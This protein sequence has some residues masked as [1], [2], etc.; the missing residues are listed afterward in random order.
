MS[1]DQDRITEVWVPDATGAGQVGSG[2]LLEDGLVLTAKHVLKDAQEGKCEVRLLGTEGWVPASEKWVGQSVDAALLE[3]GLQS[4]A[5]S[6]VLWG[7]IK[8]KELTACTAV[9]FPWAQ[10]RPDSV[11]DTEQLFGH[12]APVTAVK[13]G[14]YGVSV[15]TSP[16]APRPDDGSPWSGMSGA[17]LFSGPYLVGV[18]VVDPGRFGPDRVGAIPV[19]TMFAD[20]EVARLVGSVL[21]A[22]QPRFRLSV[23]AGVSFPPRAPYR[24][25]P[26]GFDPHAALPQLLLQ[27]HGVVP[28]CPGNTT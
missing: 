1:L 25:L 27:E 24:P 6:H 21:T 20:E 8:G 10:E 23:A 7:E 4:P 5:H 22:I 11:R 13:E 17:A 15:I 3:S 12:I 2:Y 16:P 9:G 18:I 14:L 19:A 28:F 26:R